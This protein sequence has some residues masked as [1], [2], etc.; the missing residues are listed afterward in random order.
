MFPAIFLDRDGVIVENRSD[1]ILSWEDVE[2][3]SQAVRALTQI[4]TSQYK[5]V[6]I[7]NQSAIGRGLL[8]QSAADEINNRLLAKIRAAGGR[9]DGLFLCPHSPTDNCVCRKPLPGLILQAAEE[10][11][12]DL[13]NSILIGD[14]ITDLKAG[15]AAGIKRLALVKTGRGAEQVTFLSNETDLSSAFIFNDLLEALTILL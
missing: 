11:S 13:S 10:L 1:Y 15:M 7:T 4:Q 14:A 12:V 2:I 3:F 5:I 8:T 9:V 6:I